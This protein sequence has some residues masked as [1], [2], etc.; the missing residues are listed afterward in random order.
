[1]KRLQSEFSQHVGDMSRGAVFVILIDEASCTSLDVF[2]LVSVILLV[3][4]P[5]YSDVF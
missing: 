2:Y 5:D 1:M 4:V 3:G